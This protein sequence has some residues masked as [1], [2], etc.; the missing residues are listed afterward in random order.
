VSRSAP[1]LKEMLGLDGDNG[2]GSITNA[3]QPD[4]AVEAT[5]TETPEV[6]ASAS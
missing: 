2:G 6:P 3:S 1:I 4:D 5:V